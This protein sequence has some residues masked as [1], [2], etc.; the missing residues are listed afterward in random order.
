[1]PASTEYVILRL[2]RGPAWTPRVTPRLL[3]L[4]VRHMAS[5]LALRRR[6]LMAVGGP[7]SGDAGVR[8]LVVVPASRLTE[9]RAA[10]ARDPAVRAGRLVIVGPDED[11]A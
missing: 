7:V 2:V 6:G 10:L 3:L 11:P 4:Q 5:L 1:M 8:G 9:A